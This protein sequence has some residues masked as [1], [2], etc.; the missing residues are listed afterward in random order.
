MQ[1]GIFFKRILM[2]WEYNLERAGQTASSTIL[3]RVCKI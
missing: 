3:L 2:K 1:G